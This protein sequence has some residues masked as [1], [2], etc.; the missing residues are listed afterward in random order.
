MFR[1]ADS[2]V[3]NRDSLRIHA[4]VTRQGRLGAIHPRVARR[5]EAFSPGSPRHQKDAGG[6]AMN[7][8]L[9]QASRSRVH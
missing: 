4:S 9:R 5:R 7:R 2:D 1:L 8:K 6:S 3:V